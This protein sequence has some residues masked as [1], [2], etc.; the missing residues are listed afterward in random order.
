MNK[1]LLQTGRTTRQVAQAIALANEGRVV[2]FLVETK[3][4]IPFVVR[5]ISIHYAKRL[6]H[7]IKV[8]VE[9]LP[10]DFDWDEMKPLSFA[11]AHPSSVWIVHHDAVERHYETLARRVM[12]IQMLMQQIYP[13]TTGADVPVVSKAAYMQDISLSLRGRTTP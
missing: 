13:F 10:A 9:V 6:S 1:H 5:R 3:N 12:E 7:G 11:S 4:M 2:Y 8:E